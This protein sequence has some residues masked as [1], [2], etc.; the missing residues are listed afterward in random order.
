MGLS[1]R[2]NRFFSFVI[3]LIKERRMR[4]KACNMFYVFF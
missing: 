3:V 2:R 4:K 1:Q